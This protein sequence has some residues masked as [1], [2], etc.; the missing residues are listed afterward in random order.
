MVEVFSPIRTP[1]AL[2]IAQY[3]FINN[4]T[5]TIDNAPLCATSIWMRTFNG[6]HHN[7]KHY[8]TNSWTISFRNGHSICSI[9]WNSMCLCVLC[10]VVSFAFFSCCFG[11]HL[12]ICCWNRIQFIIQQEYK[13]MI[14]FNNEDVFFFVWSP[15]T[16]KWINMP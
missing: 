9:N 14:Y 4:E 11:R 6:L 1:N 12:I 10:R 7:D 5:L 16:D 8:S 15:D 2:P 13:R 3:L